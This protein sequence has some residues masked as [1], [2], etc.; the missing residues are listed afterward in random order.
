V[1]AKC[2]GDAFTIQTESGLSATIKVTADTEIKGE[3]NDDLTCADIAVGDRVN[4]Q[5]EPTP[6]AGDATLVAN[7]IVVHGAHGGD[8]GQAA[9]DADDVHGGPGGDHGPSG[10]N[11]GRGRS[12]R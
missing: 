2:T 3:G 9:A 5:G 7:Q 4:V 12:G 10:S 1:T 8:H 11:G 6:A